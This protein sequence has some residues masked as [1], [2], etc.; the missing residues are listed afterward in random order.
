MWRQRGLPRTVEE[1]PADG[2]G[3]GRDPECERGPEAPLV[4][5]DGLGDELPDGA[6]L[7]RKRRRELFR[8]RTSLTDSRRA[9]A[10][11]V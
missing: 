1:G 6:S 11:E 8:H 9:K 4:E 2:E 3:R 7:R 5:A 10:G